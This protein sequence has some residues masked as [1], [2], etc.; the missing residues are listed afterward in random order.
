TAN[1]KGPWDLTTVDAQSDTDNQVTLLVSNVLSG[2]PTIQPT[3]Q[4]TVVRLKLKVSEHEKPYVESS[5]I[6]GTGFAEKLDPN[7]LVVGPTGLALG[8]HEILYVADTI[9]NRITAIPDALDRKSPTNPV[10]VSSGDKLN[11]PLGMQLAP[12]GNILTVNAGDGNL[13]ETRPD[14]RQVGTFQ[15]SPMG[16]GTL[17]NLLIVKGKGIYFVNDGTNTLNLLSGSY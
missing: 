14:G 8:E 4:G 13:V 5:T 7:N 12:N 2:S 15:L 10:E 17:F 11:M 16:A 6:I 9:N 3:N 1:I